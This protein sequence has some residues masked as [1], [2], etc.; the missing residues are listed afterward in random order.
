MLVK[1]LQKD[2]LKSSIT[3]EQFGKAMSEL[4]LSDVPEHRKQ[5]AVMDHVAKIMA[6]TIHDRAVAIDLIGARL[7]KAKN[8]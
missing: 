6:G 8:G 4:D 1:N 5:E 2:A 7:M 3:P